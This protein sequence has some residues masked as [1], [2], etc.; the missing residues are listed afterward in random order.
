MITYASTQKCP[1]FGQEKCLLCKEEAFFSVPSL[2]RTAKLPWKTPENGWVGRRL[3]FLLGGRPIFSG[4]MAV[5][6]R[7]GS[8]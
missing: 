4:K 3:P 2:K 1:G 8:L 6:F 7:E 5:S